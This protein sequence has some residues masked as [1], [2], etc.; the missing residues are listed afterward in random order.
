MEREKKI[1]QI[2]LISQIGLIISCLCIA[3][4]TPAAVPDVPETWSTVSNV[5]G[6]TR[7]D[8]SVTLG[9]PGGQLE[10]AFRAI[11]GPTTPQSSIATATTNASGN[12]Y[13]GNY[14]ADGAR[15]I[16]FK[17]RALDAIPSA[18]WVVLRGAATSNEWHVNLRRPRVGEWTDYRISLDYAAGWTIGPNST[19]AAY[20]SDLRSIAWAGVYVRRNGN[21]AAQRY[22]VD[23]FSLLSV[24]PPID[25]GPQPNLDIK[26]NSSGKTEIGWDSAAGRRYGLW[27]STNLVQGTFIKV[28]SNIDALPPRNT[29]EDV[30]ATGFGVYFY[31]VNIETNR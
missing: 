5:S 2:G 25:Y 31:R 24:A 11:N 15:G 16:S 29:F 22:H 10:M 21:P 14:E 27:R 18:V 1:R 23:D 7:T 20:L 17:F 4:V 3:A 19:S 8:S 28:R 30:D 6:W 12:R 26:R 13:T 9:N